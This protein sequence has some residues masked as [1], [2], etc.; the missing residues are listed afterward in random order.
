MITDFASEAVAL[1]VEIEGL[2]AAI[3]AE[4]ARTTEL[5]AEIRSMET[6]LDEAWD[7]YEREYRWAFGE[8]GIFP[9]I[10]KRWLPVIFRLVERIDAALTDDQKK[11]FQFTQIKEKYNG[12]RV[13]Y[14]CDMKADGVVERLVEQAEEEV[15]HIETVHKKLQ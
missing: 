6:D 14:N 15:D 11:D 1:E 8:R 3:G 4:Q 5:N 7:R 13:Y 12:L 10:P 9:E 2:F